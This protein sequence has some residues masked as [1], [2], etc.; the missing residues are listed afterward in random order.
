MQALRVN[1][2]LSELP[3]RQGPANCIL[4]DQLREACPFESSPKY[5]AL[6]RDGKYGLELLAAIRS[7]QIS[8][9]RASF[10]CPWQNGVAAR[11]VENRRKDLLDH[12]IA[13]NEEYLWRLLREYVC[14]CH[15]DRTL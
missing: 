1:H 9:V 6:D 3:N 7:L 15:E 5:L 10:Q 2:L 12:V 14:Y 11:W 8:P 4:Q 13:L